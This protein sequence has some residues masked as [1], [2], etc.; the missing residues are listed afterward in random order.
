[1]HN[2][3]I[4]DDLNKQQVNDERVQMLIKRGRHNNIS[5]FVKPGR[6]QESSIIS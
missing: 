3:I 6:T 4:L 2:V 5:V 1:M